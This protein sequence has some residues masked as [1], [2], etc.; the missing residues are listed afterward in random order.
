[1][2][3]ASVSRSVFPDR[4]KNL[5][6][7]RLVISAMCACSSTDGPLVK[8]RSQSVSVA[9]WSIISAYRRDSTFFP[10]VGTGVQN[11]VTSAD[12]TITPKALRFFAR[13][14][15]KI[16]LRSSSGGTDIQSL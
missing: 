2:N 14:L 11:D 9:K 15:R 16:E 12:L 7:A 6:R 8:T 1:M 4:L 5:C 13:R 10:V 3:A